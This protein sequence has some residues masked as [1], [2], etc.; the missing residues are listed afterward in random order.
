MGSRIPLRSRTA[1]YYTPK[2]L[3]VVLLFASK[4]RPG[5][6]SP[7]ESMKGLGFR[8]LGFRVLGFRV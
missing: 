7:N 3:Q 1:A 4:P 8:G 2:Q 5:T 6:L